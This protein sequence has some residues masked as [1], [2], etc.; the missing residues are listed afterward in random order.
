MLAVAVVVGAT[1]SG[2]TTFSD[3]DVAARVGDA[4]LTQD[5][6]EAVLADFP[7]AEGAD[8]AAGA[9]ALQILSFW[10]QTQILLGLIDDDGGEVTAADLDDTRAELEATDPTF[11]GLSPTSKDLIVENQAATRV[12][13][14]QFA[15]SADELRD[16][17]EAGPAGGI[18]CT[19]HLL[20]GT[21]ADAE[22]A[23][24]RLD[25][26][27]PFGDVAADVS[28][29]PGSAAQGGFLGCYPTE[30]FGT[31]FV[32]E[33]V[34]GALAAEIGVPTD[35]VQSDFG[36]HVIELVPFDEVDVTALEQVATQS[37]LGDQQAL[38]QEAAADLDAH[39]DPRYGYYTGQLAQ[40]VQPLG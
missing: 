22:A 18:V 37:S 26:G 21:A 8:E 9:T 34:D 33:F 15:P 20:V 14:R 1:L 17:Y 7:L 28:T 32:P 19:R 16:V 24:T 23:L 35:P 10:M 29:D 30:E 40:L 27:E 11:A 5:D 6:F 12:W 38:L 31:T 36:F 13:Q 2:C 39:V 25:G 4:E 3:N